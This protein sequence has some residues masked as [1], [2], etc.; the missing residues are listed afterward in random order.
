MTDYIKLVITDVPVDNYDL[1]IELEEFI[2]DIIGAA[3]PVP[4]ST[5]ALE[6]EEV[7]PIWV[8]SR[9]FMSW[10]ATTKGLYIT[11]NNQIISYK[12]LKGE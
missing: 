12:E 3:F 7:K 10:R 9:D 8:I 4:V 11:S 2:F 6:R 5:F 1:C